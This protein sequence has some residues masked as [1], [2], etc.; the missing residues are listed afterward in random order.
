YGSFTGCNINAVTKSG[1]NELHG[2]AFFD[3]SNDSLR[4][5]RLEGNPNYPNGDYT[6][7]RYGA[8]L[9]GPIVKDKLFFFASYEKLEGADLFSRIPSEDT[10][11]QADL[12]RIA[13]IAQ[14]VYGYTVG[15]VVNS[16][17]TEDEKILAK[18]DW[19][20]NDNHRL[21]L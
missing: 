19:N 21:A 17:P 8:H 1:S 12:D 6:S 14:D 9:G 11:T 10:V 4:A 2:G 20:I 3:Y 7:K 18:I 13:Q 15:D 5:S 16:L